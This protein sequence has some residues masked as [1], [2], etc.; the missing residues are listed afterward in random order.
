MLK[1]ILACPA[2]RGKQNFPSYRKPGSTAFRAKT[3]AET[4]RKK[5]VK[6]EILS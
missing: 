4:K 1:G 5:A 2:G 3:V 6:R